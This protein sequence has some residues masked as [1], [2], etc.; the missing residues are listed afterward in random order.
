MRGTDMVTNSTY[1]AADL[2]STKVDSQKFTELVSIPEV[3]ERIKAVI[4]TEAPITEWLLIKRVIN[5][6]QVYK[7]GGRIRPFMEEI[8]KNMK[9]K[10]TEDET[11][12]VYWKS[13]QNPKTWNKV[14]TF[15]KYEETCRDVTLVPTVE[16]ANALEFILQRD[17]L[18]HDDLIRTTAAFLG[19]TRMG[20]NVRAGMERGLKYAIKNK[21][22]RS[23]RNGTMSL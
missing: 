23:S 7:A 21:K 18:D 1:A 17:A 14:R 12:T 4:I 8:L 2:P 5:S 10:T 13:S 6:F 11:G 3:K 16:I 15:G 22:I 9:L 19:Y 20:S